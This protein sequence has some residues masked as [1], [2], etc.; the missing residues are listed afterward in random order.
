MSLTLLAEDH[1]TF[2]P[3]ENA[4]TDPDGLLAIGG[5]LSPERLEAAYRH[6]CFPWFNSGDPILWWS[7]N[8]RM[9]LFPKDFH[10]SRS[11]SKLLKR[12]V[13][14]V[15]FDENFA[16]VIKACSEPRDYTD[17]TWIT[18]EMQQAYIEMHRRGLAH[19]VEVWQGD[20]LVGGLYGMVLGQLFFGESMFSRVT[21]ASK[22]GFCHLVCKLRDAGIVLID[23]QM[24]TSHLQSLGAEMISRKK[25]A[26]YVRR[27]QHEPVAIDWQSSDSVI[28]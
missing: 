22:F 3:L 17:Q 7:P 6:G 26:E 18:E 9:V 25:F 27:Y 12:K 23:C 1:L 15:T 11:M 20:L 19:S 2:P 5:D 16:A 10:V 14:R 28:L 4:L 13:F 24:H 8:P 21:N